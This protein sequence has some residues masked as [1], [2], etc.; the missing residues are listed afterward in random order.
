M[1]VSRSIALL[2]AMAISAVKAVNNTSSEFF[3]TSGY[4]NLSLSLTAV[5]ETGDI[6]FRWL[7]P[8]EYDW[9]AFGIGNQMKGSFSVVMY[10]S[11]NGSGKCAQCVKLN[12]GEI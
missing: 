2:S 3:Y 7:A 11:K 1:R 4:A 5:A 12:L 9:V 8:S 6:F 10:T